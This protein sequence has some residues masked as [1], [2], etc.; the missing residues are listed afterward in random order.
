MGKL[1]GYMLTWTTYGTW[2][3]GESKGYV[4]GGEI[5]GEN[6]KLRR[7]NLEE[8][9]GEKVILGERDRKIIHDAILSEGPRMKQDILA[10][11]VCSNHVHIVLRSSNED[12]SEVVKRFKKAAY[13]ALRE[14]G[15]VGKAWTRGYD[16][17]FCFDEESLQA[18]VGYVERHCNG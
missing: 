1:I 2:L 18:R 12:I 14:N 15:F 6:Q 9:S 3:Q 16:K 11:N 10:L 8:M 4:K 7:K 17:R 13:F 5:L